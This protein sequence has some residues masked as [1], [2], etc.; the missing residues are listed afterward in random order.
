[1]SPCFCELSWYRC[2][3]I[4]QPANSFRALCGIS[5]WTGSSATPS[6]GSL[7][8][9]P[10]GM[11]ALRLSPGL[12][13]KNWQRCPRWFPY[14]RLCFHTQSAN[15]FCSSVHVRGSFARPDSWPFRSSLSCWLWQVDLQWQSPL[16]S[17]DRAT[18]S[19]QGAGDILLITAPSFHVLAW[20]LWS[21]WVL[22]QWVMQR[23][24]CWI[25]HPP[26]VSFTISF[27]NPG[28]GKVGSDFFV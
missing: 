3:V 18:G 13:S 25:R 23:V 15:V 5:E 1:M 14:S 21:S 8:G 6:D 17:P 4:C 20:S 19:V 2:M 9:R 22:R 26:R 27:P 11:E 12:T 7:F 16:F 10:Y 24:N 28:S